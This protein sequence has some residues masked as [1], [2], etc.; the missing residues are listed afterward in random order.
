MKIYTKKGDKGLTQLLGGKIIEKSH[1]RINAY[2]NIDELNAHIG[3]LHDQE[4]DDSHK[5]FLKFIQVQ[6]LN[7]GSIVSYDGSKTKIKLPEVNI[8]DIERIESQIDKMESKLDTLTG[9]IL[10][11]G[12]KASSL[13]HI[14]RTVCR[15]AERSI[16]LLAEK[17]DVDEI[18]IIFLNRLSDYL[19]VLSRK[20]LQENNISDRLWK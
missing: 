3:H 12:H 2:G 5:K 14:A 8:S 4:I 13:S 17:E 19:F 18:P 15:R 6:L 9:F 1:V 11:S 7:L 20:I 16:V 10:P